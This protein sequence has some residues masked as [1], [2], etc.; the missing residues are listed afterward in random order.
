MRRHSE[1]NAARYT[2]TPA[3]AAA[4]PRLRDPDLARELSTTVRDAPPLQKTERLQQDSEDAGISPLPW[5]VNQS[6]GGGGLR[7]PVPVERGS[8]ALPHPRKIS[9]PSPSQTDLDRGESGALA[10]RVLRGILSTPDMKG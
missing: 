2:D 7:A 8:R 6:F 10:G 3:T 9:A 5:P 4:E 1:G